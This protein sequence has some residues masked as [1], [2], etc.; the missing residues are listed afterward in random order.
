MYFLTVDFWW[1]RL[2]LNQRSRDYQS[3]AL[4]NWATKPYIG[5]FCFHKVCQPKLIA[6]LNCVHQS[7]SDLLLAL[8]GP[9][10]CRSNYVR[11]RELYRLLRLPICYWPRF[12]VSQY[13][14]LLRNRRVFSLIRPQL[15]G[16]PGGTRTHK[17]I[18]HSILSAARI[19]IPPRVHMRPLIF[20]RNGSLK[21]RR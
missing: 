7:S 11:R 8:G 15:P 14:R 19:P 9:G 20:T 18:G 2:D 1:S 12:F 10:W 4:T 17:P 3:R 13:S 6:N 21:P 5:S 16:A